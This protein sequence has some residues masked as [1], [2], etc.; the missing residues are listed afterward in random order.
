MARKMHADSTVSLAIFS[1]EKSLC[2]LFGQ[3]QLS[4][5]A[6]EFRMACSSLSLDDKAFAK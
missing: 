2:Q 6:N 4:L 5:D 3:E 1:R